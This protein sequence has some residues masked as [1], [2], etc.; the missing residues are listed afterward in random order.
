M[1]S[2]GRPMRLAAAYASVRLLLFICRDFFSLRCRSRLCGPGPASATPCD[3]FS[4]ASPW[5][6]PWRLDLMS[7]PPAVRATCVPMPE[8]HGG[9][10]AIGLH[11]ELLADQ[12]PR[13]PIDTWHVLT[14]V[15]AGYGRAC[16]G[17]GFFSAAW[18]ACCPAF[19]RAA[20]GLQHGKALCC[21]PCLAAIARPWRRIGTCRNGKF[22]RDKVSSPNVKRS[23]RM[24]WKG[25]SSRRRSSIQDGK[26]RERHDKRPAL[27]R[28]CHA[29]LTRWLLAHWLLLRT[30]A[31]SGAVCI[32]GLGRWRCPCP[33]PRQPW[34]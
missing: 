11:M 2:I 16:C 21:H 6:R 25:R 1:P 18:T 22:T 33:S 12:S 26:A 5:F 10:L 20:A 34:Q 8:C 14:Y 31:P 23:M 27:R 29:T 28:R 13:L 7:L 15:R 9:C 32:Q 3:A 17:P 19:L 24:H 4:A 30:L